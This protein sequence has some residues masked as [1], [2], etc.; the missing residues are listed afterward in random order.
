MNVDQRVVNEKSEDLQSKSVS[1]TQSRR[2]MDNSW[3]FITTINR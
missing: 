1:L 2:E 3:I